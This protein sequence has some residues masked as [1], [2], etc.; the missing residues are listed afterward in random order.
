[1]VRTTSPSAQASGFVVEVGETPFLLTA[2]EVVGKST[3]RLLV[4]FE[5]ANRILD[6]ARLGVVGAGRAVVCGVTSANFIPSLDI[7]PL[8]W[9]PA[10]SQPVFSLGYLRG[11]RGLGGAGN[12][13]FVLGGSV[14][15]V[16]GE[17]DPTFYIDGSFNPGMVGG[18][19]LSATAGDVPTLAGVVLGRQPIKT[20][21]AV[22][23]LS[24]EDDRDPAVDTNVVAV[25]GMR[26]VV[27]LIRSVN[28]EEDATS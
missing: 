16:S 19:V 28:Q 15:A 1:M 13:P 17:D 7:P 11:I 26:A 8:D 9:L 21:G 2:A 22:G 25:L 10:A 24:P 3:Q 5:Q 6:V 14:A 4:T 23:I 27:D 18:P 20:K 12:V